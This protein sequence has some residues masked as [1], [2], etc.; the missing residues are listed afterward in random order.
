MSDTAFLAQLIANMPKKSK[1]DRIR[2]EQKRAL[3]YQRYKPKVYER[4]F[5]YRERLKK[6]MVEAYGGAC[7]GCGE[8]D[9][10]V[11]VI[12]HINDDAPIDRLI[13]NHSGGYRMYASLRKRGWPKEGYQLLCHNCN[14]R[15]E[16]ERRGHAVYDS[17]TG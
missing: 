16:Y 14:F 10:I 3:E 15:K 4:E 1:E 8:A 12:D 17:E 7:V 2:D 5:A 6:Q 13:H 11:L 9:Y